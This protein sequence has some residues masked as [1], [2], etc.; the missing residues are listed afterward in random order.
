MPEGEAAKGDNHPK[1]TKMQR[2][3]DDADREN[4][5]YPLQVRVFAFS[6]S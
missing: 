4:K 5:L 6:S 2:G 1:M 3:K